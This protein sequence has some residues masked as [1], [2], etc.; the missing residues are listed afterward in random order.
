MTKDPLLE[1]PGMIS[2]TLPNTMYR[3]KLQGDREIIAALAETLHGTLPHLKVE[4]RVLV[5]IKPYD[6]GMGRI[7]FRLP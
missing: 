1:L 5:E 4:D 6:L 7:V 3:V 2:E